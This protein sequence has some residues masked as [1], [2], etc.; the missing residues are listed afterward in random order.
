MS[1]V[2]PIQVGF[3]FS[4]VFYSAARLSVIHNKDLLAT[5]HLL[6]AMVKCFQPELDLPPN[7]KVD[8]VVVEVSSELE[9]QH[10]FLLKHIQTSESQL[11]LIF[12]QVGKSGIKSDIDTEVLTGERWADVCVIVFVMWGKLSVHLIYIIFFLFQ[13]ETQAQTP[14]AILNVSRGGWD[15][16][17]WAD[18]TSWMSSKQHYGL[19]WL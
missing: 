6:V 4:S 11:A 9:L 8:V 14:R 18:L 5:I 10:F 13:T 17:G 19:Q 12:N 1:S 16:G 3:F 7:V 15:V 2:I